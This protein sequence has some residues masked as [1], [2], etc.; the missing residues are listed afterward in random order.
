MKIKL[1]EFLDNSSGKLSGSSM[2]SEILGPHIPFCQDS[3]NSLSDPWSMVTK[4]CMIKHVGWG[5]QH[6]SR[7]GNV[8]SSN[9]LSF[10]MSELS[11]NLHFCAFARGIRLQKFQYQFIRKFWGG[12][13]IF[14]MTLDLQELFLLKTT[15]TVRLL[16]LSGICHMSKN[17]WIWN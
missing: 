7:I 16:N 12:S 13:I 6:A 11:L 8:L 17:A 2:S 3:I 10:C 14:K 15:C 5:Q 1:I 4:S 9:F